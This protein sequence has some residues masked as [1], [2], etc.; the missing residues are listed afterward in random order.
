MNRRITKAA[1]LVVGVA[2]ATALLAACQQPGSVLKGRV[3]TV[4]GAGVEGVEVR[5]YSN[6][7]DELVAHGTT[8]GDGDFSFIPTQ[9]PPGTWRLRFGST[10]WWKDATSWADATP[11]TGTVDSPAV[12][13]LTTGA[14]TGSASGTVTDAGRPTAG[15]TVRAIRT[16]TGE[17]AATTTTASDGTFA[18]G[19]LA[20]GSYVFSFAK[21]GLTTRYNGSALTQETAATIPIVV[22]RA[23]S[24][25]DAELVAMSTITGKVTDGTSA[26]GGIAVVAIDP[27]SQQIRSSTTTA[28]DGT[29]TLQPLEAVAAIVGFGDPSGGLRPKIYGSASTDPTTGTPVT[30][31]GGTIDLGTVVIGPPADFCATSRAAADFAG[32]DLAGADLSGCDLTGADLTGANLTGADLTGADLS[33]ATVKDATFT[34]ATLAGVRAIDVVGPPT[35][36]PAGWQYLQISNI[37]GVST[38]H[39]VGPGVDLSGIYLRAVSLADADLHGADLSGATILQSNVSGADLSDADLTDA[40]FGP[41]LTAIGVDFSDADLTGAYLSGGNFTD[42]TF[43]GATMAGAEI[44]GSVTL[45]GVRSGG[46]TG[47]VDLPSNWL[48]VKGYLI[49]RDADLAGADLSGADLTGANLLWVDLSTANLTGVRS[50]DLRGFPSG[51][52][53]GWFLVY[54]RLF[55][56]GADHSGTDL[57]GL[58]FTSLLLSGLT[59]SGIDFAGATFAG[60]TLDGVDLTGSDLAGATFSGASGLAGANLTGVSLQGTSIGDDTVLTGVISSGVT[61]TPAHLPPGWALV[62]GVL[63]FT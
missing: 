57:S 60:S 44:S 14:T 55:G 43:T 25:I 31:I 49:G 51:L 62:G 4:G 7:T 50:A 12:V 52:P 48:L 40:T 24:G 13:D 6:A 26:R 38:G 53:T 27:A 23:V 18:F 58:D 35:G 47:T 3:T 63:V 46:I 19:E 11:V 30:P 41:S 39:L 21:L 32:A 37:R 17:V 33:R 2:I 5:V 20:G 45:T 28:A 42:T 29:F 15:A 54:G 36:L 9:L 59:L 8:D 16:T 56:P 22:G 10:G 61:G 34:G 1:A